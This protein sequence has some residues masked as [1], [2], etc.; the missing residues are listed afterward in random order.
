MK[1][2]S[3]QLDLRYNVYLAPTLAHGRG[4]FAG[5]STEK[6]RPAVSHHH[7][8]RVPNKRRRQQD[9]LPIALNIVEEESSLFCLPEDDSFCDSLYHQQSSSTLDTFLDHL[10]TNDF[11]PVERCI[12]FAAFDE[13]IEIPHLKDLSDDE[14]NSVWMTCEEWNAMRTECAELTNIMDDAPSMDNPFAFYTRGLASHTEVHRARKQMYRD[15][16]YDAMSHVLSS[17][18]NATKGDCLEALLAEVSRVCSATAVEDAI[19]MAAWDEL[20]VTC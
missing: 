3:S 20:Q 7:R 6:P 9:M 13:V 11:E 12:T 2:E 10:E 1:Q 18:Q 15:V 8:Y 19:A 14:I 4:T 5:V 16:M 17:H